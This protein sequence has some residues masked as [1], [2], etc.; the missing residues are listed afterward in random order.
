VLVSSGPHADFRWRPLEPLESRTAG[1][2]FRW[3]PVEPLEIAAL[4]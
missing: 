1:R 3:R 2:V 4:E